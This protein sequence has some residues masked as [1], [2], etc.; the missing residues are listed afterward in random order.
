MAVYPDKIVLKSSTDG[1]GV[2]KELIHPLT[3]TSP[4]V[5]GELVISRS[6]GEAKI[7]TIDSN[8][9]PVTVSQGS[10]L[11][12]AAP[13]VILNMEG[14]GLDTPS[15]ALD[16]AV[17]NPTAA[18]AR[19]GT[20]G[21]ESNA[22]S[23]EQFLTRKLIQTENAW[24]VGTGKFT[25]E[26]WYKSDPDNWFNFDG[27]SNP[28]S[29]QSIISNLDYP[30]G[31]GSF[32]VYVDAG[33]D[34]SITGKAGIAFGAVV[35]GLS[36]G[37][38]V[39]LG[40]Y[41]SIGVNSVGYLVSSKTLTVVDNEWHYIVFQH[42]GDG[43]YTCHVDGKLAEATTYSAPVNFDDHGR[44]EGNIPHPV[45]INFGGQG[46]GT[47]DG[48]YN[49]TGFKGYLDA[50]AM[51]Q[52]MARY[53]T[54]P[55]FVVPDSAPEAG[56]TVFKMPM[57]LG[58][59]SDVYMSSYDDLKNN[60]PLTFNR[61]SG[62]WT[63]GAS[64]RPAPLGVSA[65]VDYSIEPSP[66]YGSSLTLAAPR[67][68][69]ADLLLA[70]IMHRTDGGALS[71]PAGWTLEGVYGTLDVSGT[72][73]QQ[74]SV[75]TK[76]ATIAEPAEYTWT[77]TLDTER[78]GG[79]ITSAAESRY[80]GV[81]SEVKTSSLTAQITT[82]PS[83]T[84][85][86]VG[87]WIYSDNAGLESSTMAAQNGLYSQINPAAAVAQRISASWGYD[88]DTID[89]THSTIAASPTSDDHALI[90][91]ELALD[92]A[93][94]LDLIS[95][96]NYS[97][98][99]QDTNILTYDGQDW[100]PTANVLD[101]LADVTIT[102]PTS[103]DILQYNG[104]EWVNAAAPAYN[105]SGNVLGDLGDV[106]ITAA[107][108][109]QYLRHD[110]TGWVNQAIQYSDIAGP[111]NFGLA[112]LTD[113]DD[114]LA[115]TDKQVLAFN[116]TEWSAVTRVIG[117]AGD[118]DT[119]TAA[120][121]LG[122]FL[123][124]DGT[125]WVPS[126]ATGTGGVSLSSYR[127][128]TAQTDAGNGTGAFTLFGSLAQIVEIVS[129]TDC[130]LTIYANTASRDADVNRLISSDPLPGSGVL[131]EFQL[132]ALTPVTVTPPIQLFNNSSPIQDAFFLLSRQTDGT[133][134]SVQV[135]MAAYCTGVVTSISGGT[136]GS[137]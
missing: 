53:G 91:I 17:S 132:T 66:G 22:S 68:A 40:D 58:D 128:Q 137:G 29:Y 3:G 64:L 62:Y 36:T 131:A 95:D 10:D 16:I 55:D 111:V 61:N 96:V 80:V 98:A 105:V 41:P 135:T 48:P 7:F 18:A 130:W 115:P 37:V 69:S 118:V 93:L 94:Q 92:S 84:C 123:S 52:G 46:V 5:P 13:R 85:L 31:P 77:T 74:L 42:L 81:S 49:Q 107:A 27:S 108:N 19:F 79:I 38:D 1:D 28:A 9:Q 20:A 102:S 32:N 90:C 70:V 35:F 6:S 21:F 75:F 134:I 4:I 136:F 47:V 101:V 129:D 56:V 120:P 44:E 89:H 67:H 2:I 30:Y 126:V 24:D 26:F 103:T 60:A 54:L 112:A 73:T 109:G 116:G 71:A 11:E 23:G 83:R 119:T 14:D 110:G 104:S 88:L 82:V 99:P 122:N 87:H 25:L 125:N 63:P 76:E 39:S 59:L 124:W 100:R 43:N 8:G 65:F 15:D 127:T 114:A 121:S 51:Y 33:G 45:G 34:N 50:L 12:S 72:N 113:V 117:D 106:T 133:A 78:I 97:P 57:S 86:V